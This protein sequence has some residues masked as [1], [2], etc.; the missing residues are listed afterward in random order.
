MVIIL[1]FER[2]LKGKSAELSLG[3]KFLKLGYFVMRAPASGRRARKF[4]YP[5]LV[6]IS[7]GKILLFEVKLR[8]H[9]D[10]IHIPWRQIENLRYASALTGGKAYVA[11]YVQEDKE[12]YFFRLSDLELQSHE[13]GKR[14]VITVGMYDKALKFSD[15]AF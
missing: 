1:S 3:K 12:W 10:T 15:I 14:F 5:D 4:K 8:K 11:I 2:Y 7:K 9:R 13:K 6:A